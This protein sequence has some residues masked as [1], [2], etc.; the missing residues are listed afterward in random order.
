VT[1]E[2]V[3]KQYVVDLFDLVL[4]TQEALGV[5]QEELLILEMYIQEVEETLGVK[6]VDPA[7]EDA[8]AYER[9]IESE[10]DFLGAIV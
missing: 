9:D 7:I 5:G 1:Q 6:R 8:V 2:A 3:L 4:A 10:D